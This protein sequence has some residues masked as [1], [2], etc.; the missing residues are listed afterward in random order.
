MY[1]LVS[2]TSMLGRCRA[3]DSID[4]WCG[5]ATLFWEDDPA[6][7]HSI[8]LEDDFISR[9]GPVSTSIFVAGRGICNEKE[10]IANISIFSDSESILSGGIVSNQGLHY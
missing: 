2:I 4:C 9:T 7:S 5:C 3:K 8:Y 6:Y 10:L 1:A